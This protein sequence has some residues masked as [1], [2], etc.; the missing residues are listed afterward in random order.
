MAPCGGHQVRLDAQRPEIVIGSEPAGELPVAR[1]AAVQ[2]ADEIAHRSGLVRP[3]GAGQQPGLPHR[4]VLDRKVAHR[5][6]PAAWVVGQRRR[7]VPRYD[8]GGEA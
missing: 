8:P 4:V 7:D 2:P 3:H 5:E 1:A 6:Q